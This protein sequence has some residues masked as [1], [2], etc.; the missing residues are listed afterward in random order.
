MANQKV[1]QQRDPTPVKIQRA[2]D[3][4]ENL[5]CLAQFK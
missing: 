2:E 5:Y 4:W 3:G 1:A